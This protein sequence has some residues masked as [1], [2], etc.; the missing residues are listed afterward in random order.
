MLPARYKLILIVYLMPDEGVYQTA[1]EIVEMQEM[2]KKRNS[3][4]DKSQSLQSQTRTSLK[5]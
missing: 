4:F 1:I 3:C 5:M 2:Y